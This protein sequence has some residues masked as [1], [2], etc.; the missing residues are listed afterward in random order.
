[1]KF[2][3]SNLFRIRTYQVVFILEQHKKKKHFEAL[4]A[5]S[6]HPTTHSFPKGRNVQIKVSCSV[7]IAQKDSTVSHAVGLLP[8]RLGLIERH[9]IRGLWWTKMT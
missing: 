5:E 8:Q 7:F 2:G 1:M 4:Q 6:L 9:S 3:F